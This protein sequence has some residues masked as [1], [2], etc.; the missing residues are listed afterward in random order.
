MCVCVFERER[1]TV[2]VSS[3]CRFDTPPLPTHIHTRSMTHCAPQSKA[4]L[5]P[6]PPRTSWM[7]WPRGIMSTLRRMD[8]SSWCA[9][10]GSLLPRSV[11]LL[12]LCVLGWDCSQL[13]GLRL[14]CCCLWCCLFFV[15]VFTSNKWGGG[16]QMLEILQRRLPHSTQDEIR[17]AAEEQRKITHLRIDKVLAD[18]VVLAKM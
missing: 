3:L 12:S 1:G 2:C 9:H 6:Q 11:C 10:Q 13:V 17:N 14:C 8:L 5:W 7:P 16:F 18:H 15:P 4:R